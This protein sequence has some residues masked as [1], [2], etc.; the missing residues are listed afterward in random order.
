MKK[1]FQLRLRGRDF[2]APVAAVL[3]SVVVLCEG[4]VLAAGVVNYTDGGATVADG[5][6]LLYL[7][8]CG[9][10]YFAFGF[11]QMWALLPITTK[12][13]EALSYDGAPFEVEYNRG[14]YLRMVAGGMALSV[15]TLGIYTP[16]M[17]ARVMRFFAEGVSHKF[18]LV[19]FRG[20]GMRLLAFTVLLLIVPFVLMSLLAASVNTSAEVDMMSFAPLVALVLVV[21]T[22]FF[23]ALYVVMIYRWCLDLTYGDKVVKTDLPLWGASLYVVG[24]MVVTVL[25][26]GLYAPAAELRTMRYVARHTY[27]EGEEQKPKRFGMSLRMWSDWGYLWVQTLLLIVT[28]G[29]YLPW[30]YA[31]VMSR[32]TERL[33]IIES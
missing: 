27:V 17:V 11:V 26:L 18:N 1:Y 19:S 29:L 9:V 31:K 24:Q 20:K 33:Y 10:L 30:F 23:T 12:T 7:L 16:W 15:I 3:L 8:L 13:I 22:L 5:G 25:T 32:F 2:L 14:D 28:F 21:G 4:L 6:W